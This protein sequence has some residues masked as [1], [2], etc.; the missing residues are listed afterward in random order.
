M[1]DLVTAYYDCASDGK[2]HTTHRPSAHATGHRE[3]LTD[4]LAI[5]DPRSRLPFSDV[6]NILGRSFTTVRGTPGR[7]K[8][9]DE[10]RGSRLP[11]QFS[12]DLTCIDLWVSYSVFDSTDSSHTSE[13]DRAVLRSL[14]SFSV[15]S[16]WIVLESNTLNARLYWV[17]RH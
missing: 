1:A 14:L 2:F 12:P 9:A 8:M 6:R 16:G 10:S 5:R 7:R 17:R 4:S 13:R 15:D 11:R 3:Q